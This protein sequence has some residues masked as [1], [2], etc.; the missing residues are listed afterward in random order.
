MDLGL[1]GKTAIVTGGG[2]G[3]GAGICEALAQEGVNVAIN[4]IVGKDE[5]T[6]FAAELSARYG[7]D[8]RPFYADVSKAEDLDAM[9]KEVV[10]AYGH[11]D[12]LVNNA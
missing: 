1:K 12:I 9:V 4:W 8:C 2:T 3:I 10:A 11:I 5:V 7:S 6:A